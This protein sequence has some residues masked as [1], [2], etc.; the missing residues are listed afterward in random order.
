MAVVDVPWPAMR[1]GMDLV[2]IPW[3]P[4]YPWNTRE[5]GTNSPALAGGG[6]GAELG[7]GSVLLGQEKVRGERPRGRS[8]GMAFPCFPTELRVGITSPQ[9]PVTPGSEQLPVPGNNNP[10]PNLQHTGAA[11]TCRSH[12]QLLPPA[13]P[14][15]FIPSEPSGNAGRAPGSSQGPANPSQFPGLVQFLGPSCL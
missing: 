11:G 8:A 2:P 4:E 14:T 1:C 12:P 6:F 7:P 5:L 10:D 15:P 13:L 3:L 9:F